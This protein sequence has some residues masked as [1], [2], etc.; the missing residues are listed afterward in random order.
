MGQDKEGSLTENSHIRHARDGIIQ[1]VQVVDIPDDYEKQVAE[2]RKLL[3]D[4][5]S[6]AGLKKQTHTK[7][8]IL[9]FNHMTY[10]FSSMIHMVLS[11]GFNITNVCYCCN[12]HTLRCLF[13]STIFFA[14]SQGILWNA[15]DHKILVF[16][17][18]K[19]YADELA[20]K[21]W[22]DG[23]KAVAMHGGKS[24]EFLPGSSQ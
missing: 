2:K 3:E 14:F 23:F 17:S 11:N 8:K 15:A 12:L 5:L 9:F 10:V 21:L 6:G 22:K 18:Q 16:V 13:H 20:D 1:T 19:Q 4:Y 7:T 24:Q